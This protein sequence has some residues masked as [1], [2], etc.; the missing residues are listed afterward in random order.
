L[1]TPRCRV[2]SGSPAATSP[3]RHPRHS[4]DPR[5]GPGRQLPAGP[6][7]ERRRIDGGAFLEGLT[8]TGEVNAN[9]AQVTGQ[10]GL[11]HAT[12]TTQNGIALTLAGARID[13]SAFL[14]PLGIDA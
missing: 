13:G 4:E 2:G 11:Q 7:P 12:L 9:T 6:R 1:T 8:A 14:D 5:A 3:T 10:L